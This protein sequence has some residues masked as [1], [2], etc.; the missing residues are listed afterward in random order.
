MVRKEHLIDFT[1]DPKEAYT[2]KVIAVKGE[3]SKFGQSAVMVIKGEEKI[4]LYGGTRA[5]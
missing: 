1:G 5:H 2:G 4:T 3:I